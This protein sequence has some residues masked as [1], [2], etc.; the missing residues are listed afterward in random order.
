MPEELC[1]V[2]PKS[3]YVSLALHLDPSPFTLFFLQIDHIP[4]Q[5][6]LQVWSKEFLGLKIAST[7]FIQARI[8]YHR[9]CRGLNEFIW[10]NIASTIFNQVRIS[11]LQGSDAIPRHPYLN[12]GSHKEA[13]EAKEPRKP[14]WPPWTP[15][16]LRSVSRRK[17]PKM[18]KKK[19]ESEN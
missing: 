7:I 8:S 2:S 15:W 3:H 14:H 11:L 13:K 19:Q 17:G 4:R 16:P 6:Y 10:L 12:Q 5:P 18:S 9:F 1:Q